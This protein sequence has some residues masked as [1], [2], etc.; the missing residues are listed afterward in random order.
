M[1]MTISFLSDTGIGSPFAIKVLQLLK[2]AV[3][4]LRS[5]PMI[6]LLLTNIKAYLT[7]KW[8]WL[9]LRLNV[10]IWTF[11]LWLVIN[12]PWYTTVTLGR[13]SAGDSDK[14][15]VFQPPTPLRTQQNGQLMVIISFAI[16]STV[17]VVSEFMYLSMIWELVEIKE[18]KPFLWILNLCEVFLYLSI[19]SFAMGNVSRLLQYLVLRRPDLPSVYREIISAFGGDISEGPFLMAV[20]FSMVVLTT[21]LKEARIRYISQFTDRVATEDDDDEQATAARAAS[22]GGSGSGSTRDSRQALFEKGMGIFTA[23]AKR[24]GAVI[25]T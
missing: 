4:L 11:V 13:Q 24:Q 10:W 22:P 5:F 2:D 8:R 20:T 21:N 19:L 17:A 12:V 14:L 16:Y 7:V 23:R 3:S 1:N 9:G 18:C 15:T 6:Y 25:W